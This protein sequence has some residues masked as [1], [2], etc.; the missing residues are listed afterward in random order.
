MGQD[1]PATRVPVLRRLVEN[2]HVGGDARRLVHFVDPHGPTLLVRDE[3]AEGNRGESVG[4]ALVEY[5]PVGVVDHHPV[6]ALG[7]NRHI[8]E[9]QW[10]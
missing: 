7:S 8:G 10:S 9:V 1:G 4:K 2:L 3:Q 5:R 6:V